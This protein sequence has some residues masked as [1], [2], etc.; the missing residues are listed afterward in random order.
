MAS[1]LAFVKKN[2][3]YI[4][5]FAFLLFVFFQIRSCVQKKEIY[6]ETSILK[7]QL[8]QKEADLKS[9]DRDLADLRAKH[10]AEV[11]AHEADRAAAQAQEKKLREADQAKS[12]RLEE[13]EKEYPNLK[14]CEE[15]LKNALAQRDEWKE[16]F[17]LAEARIQ[18]KDKKI[19]SLTQDYKSEKDLRIKTEISRDEWKVA[20]EKEKALNISQAL[21]FNKILSSQKRKETLKEIL[22]GLAGFGL[23]KL[24]GVLK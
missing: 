8:E 2:F 18:E 1:L 5:I 20:F 24:A 9:R 15:R 6:D 23:G 17:T 13:L 3:K 4:L 21:D 10:E 14:T 7:G 16:K 19:F 22:Y 12:K 11:T